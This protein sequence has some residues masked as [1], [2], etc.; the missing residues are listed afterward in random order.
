MHDILPEVLEWASYKAGP[1]PDTLAPL[2][3]K[4]NQNDRQ[5]PNLQNTPYGGALTSFEPS[6][7]RSFLA[8]RQAIVD[9]W[10]KN[11][12]KN[13]TLDNLEN[14]RE[15]LSSETQIKR[16]A[17]KVDDKHISGKRF[18]QD[19]IADQLRKNQDAI[20]FFVDFA[21][22]KRIE[23]MEYPKRIAREEIERI[24]QVQ[25]NEGNE[26][27]I[28][29]INKEITP[30]E[31]RHQQRKLWFLVHPDRNRE[32]GSDDCAKLVNSAADTLLAQN[33][34]SYKPPAGTRSDKE[35]E[36]MFGP[37]AYGSEP[38]DDDEEDDTSQEIPDIPEVIKK[39]HSKME[40]SIKEYFSMSEADEHEIPDRIR[41]SNNKIQRL[42][43]EANIKP[44]ELYM[45]DRDVL[46]SLKNE[47]LRII[48]IQENEGAVKAKKQLAVFEK[49]CDKTC[50]QPKFQWPTHWAEI[51]AE[52]VR[53]K[54]V[55]MNKSNRQFGGQGGDLENIS[56]R[57]AGSL[58]PTTEVSE[59]DNG[60]KQLGPGYTSLGDRILGY[61]PIRKYNR[62]EDMVVTSSVT[63][64]V[65]SP[66]S[67]IF[68][69]LSEANI[70]HAALAYDRLPVSE[71]NDVETHLRSVSDG[72]INLGNYD[73]ILAIGAKDSGYEY[74]NRYPDTWVHIAVTGDDEPS[75]AKIIHRTAFRNLVG[76]R[77]ADKMIDTFYVNNGIE[78]PWATTP[79]PDPENR[80]L[81]DPHVFPA[82]R[83]R[84][85]E[86]PFRRPRGIPPLHPD[87][88]SIAYGGEGVRP[89]LAT[90]SYHE[91]FDPRIQSGGE[92][93]GRYHSTQL[94]TRSH[95]SELEPR[96]HSMQN[97][98]EDRLIRAIEELMIVSKQ[99]DQRLELMESALARIPRGESN[100][101]N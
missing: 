96:I 97:G 44:V 30:S 68:R 16:I 48:A 47:Q 59:F 24:L 62:F 50:G 61:R 72:S 56:M 70:G 98:V 51:M 74:H 22:D 58:S 46:Q 84:A 69:V 1:E 80:A 43:A 94:M 36:G 3:A 92:D 71:K 10:L 35:H 85:W 7:Q 5:N 100:T 32:E 9:S 27:E 91:N 65:E 12:L 60:S 53:G 63:Y 6:L 45:V 76:S 13:A 18:T 49:Q 54:L 37:G 19:F 79:Y 87:M 21:L 90:R 23:E 93:R 11:E 29:G 4:E 39:E 75:K 42:N 64:F 40:K 34:K 25:R 33:K 17:R 28:L 15:V 86:S 99:Q 2:D 31:L 20:D 73:K 83:Q 26:Y 14:Y 66:G 41:K 95:P 89:N 88:R 78:P 81:Y 52:A 77:D 101:E 57:D 67:P 38:E 8:A 82:P 55:E